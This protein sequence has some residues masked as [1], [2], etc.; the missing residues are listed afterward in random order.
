MLVD[1]LDDALQRSRREAALVDCRCSRGDTVMPEDM[2]RQRGAEASSIQPTTDAAFAQ[3]FPTEQSNAVDHWVVHADSGPEL[4]VVAPVEFHFP[5]VLDEFHV[6][7]D[8]EERGRRPATEPERESSISHMSVTTCDLVRMQA[9]PLRRA[10][11][12]PER[13]ALMYRHRY[14]GGADPEAL[15]RLRSTPN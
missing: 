7:C 3:F 11:I 12:H 13:L 8:G 2:Y 9:I 15:D 4:K 6:H 1:V 5:D 10:P 14:L